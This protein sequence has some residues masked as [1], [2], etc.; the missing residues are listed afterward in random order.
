MIRLE[1][2]LSPRYEHRLLGLMLIFLHI[3]LWW[4]FG[5]PL[6][7]SLMLAHLGLFLIWQPLW[8]REHRLDWRSTLIFV[9]VTLV[10]VIWY[11]R[12]LMTFWLLLLI[13]LVGGRITTRTSE[14]IIYLMCL[15]VLVSEL[16]IACIPP[17]FAVNTL[18]VEV[19][20]LFGYGLLV[21]PA[22]FFLFP[23]QQPKLPGTLTVDFLYGLTMSLLASI[24]ALG[25]LLSM[26]A[27]GAPYAVA[28]FQTILG[29]AV[30]L[31]A[32]SWLWM[33]IAGFSGLGQLWERYL[34]NIGTPFEHWLARLARLS[35][36]QQSLEEFVESSTNQLMDLP[37]VTGVSSRTALH[38][39][40]KGLETLHQFSRHDEGLHITVYA[41]RPMGTALLLHG[42]LLLQ[43]VGHFYAAKR[44]EQELTQR[45]H[46]QAIYE[47]G[48]RVTH[49][50]KNLLQSMHTVSVAVQQ[51]D[52]ESIDDV[53]QLLKRQLP[54]LTARLQL[55]LDKLQTPHM[56]EHDKSRLRDWWNALQHRNE[57]DD[58]HFESK[59][60]ANP[61]IPAGFFDSIVENL[62]ENARQKRQ[63]E[64]DIKISV[65]LESTH[66]ATILRVRDTGSA[67]DPSVRKRLFTAAV[68]SRNGLGIGLYQAAKQG[69]QLGYQ[70]K[71]DESQASGV[72]FTLT[73]PGERAS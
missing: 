1:E 4:D 28:L 16:L 34:Q 52:D 5:G 21:F 64:T 23:A 50:I 59:I 44:H 65:S 49:D 56:S 51:A 43:L 2:L 47:T 13:G 8:G 38:E 62:L 36:R 22:S 37:W 31:L 55:A 61:L 69:E 17:M 39:R 15:V 18:G 42:N 9:G 32:I 48:A 73:G 35:Q 40:L 7:R 68:S 60:D 20:V 63:L 27:T 24:L 71:L 11:D 10:F 19:Q 72:C 29:I 66:N 41:E 57:T 3:A 14:R 33:P 53:Q 54:H 67:I 25:S 12:W 70:L 45:A 58:I 30:F 46:I 6:S 26:Y